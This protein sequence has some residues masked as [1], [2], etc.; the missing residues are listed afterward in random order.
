MKNYNVIVYDVFS[1]TCDVEAESEEEAIQKVKDGKSR[2]M[3][4]PEQCYQMPIE[5]VYEVI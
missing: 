2:S 5:E 1:R 4:D 3:S